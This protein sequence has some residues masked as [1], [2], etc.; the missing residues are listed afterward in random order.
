[1][2]DFTKLFNTKYGQIL[3]TNDTRLNDDYE[4]VPSI[5]ASFMI[6]DEYGICEISLKF[7]TENEGK[8]DELFNNLT[9]EQAVQMVEKTILSL[10]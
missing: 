10:R 1:M 4:D 6:S 7:T 3:V 5:N 2:R 9:E 8:C